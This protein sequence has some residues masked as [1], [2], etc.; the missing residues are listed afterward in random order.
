MDTLDMFPK[1]KKNVVGLLDFQTEEV[2]KVGEVPSME[3]L[4]VYKNFNFRVPYI[5]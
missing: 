1:I 4:V 5:L 3:T 2:S